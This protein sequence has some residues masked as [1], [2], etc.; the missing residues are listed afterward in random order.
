M[1]ELN[2][3]EVTKNEENNGEINF[4]DALEDSF[5]RIQAGDIIKGKVIGFNANEVFVDLGY[6]ADGIISLEEYTD[7][8]DFQ[9]EKEVKIGDEIEVFVQQIND[10][11]GNV[12]LSKKQVEANKAWEEVE[13]AYEDK[14]PLKAIVI[15]VVNGGVVA[16]YKGVR[17]FVP[18]S[19]LSDRYVKDLR[20]YLKRTIELRLIDFNEKRRKLVGSARVILEERKEK[21]LKRFGEI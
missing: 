17:I 5:V 8:P 21:L 6:K 4:A 2:N 16:S 9:I 14:T 12:R 1:S 11:E 10:G 20:E 3:Q 13:K 19:Q 18:G 15:E 7:I